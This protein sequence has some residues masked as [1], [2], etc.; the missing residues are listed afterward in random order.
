MKTT[1][2]TWRTKKNENGT[3]TGTCTQFEALNTINAITG[4]YTTPSIVLWSG[5]FKSRAIAK[6]NAQKAVRYYKIK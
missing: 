4:N 1:I 6:R 5:T 2:T 3:F